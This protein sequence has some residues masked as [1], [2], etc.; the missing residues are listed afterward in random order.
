MR[1]CRIGAHCLVIKQHR[2]IRV[3]PS[4]WCLQWDKGQEWAG[5]VILSGFQGCLVL[6][7]LT[8]CLLSPALPLGCEDQHC[9]PVWGCSCV[10][11][12][13]CCGCRA[14]PVY[15]L[16]SLILQQLLVAH[17]TNKLRN[18]TAFEP[19]ASAPGWFWLGSAALW[20]LWFLYR[21]GL[22]PPG[23]TWSALKACL[24]E[25]LLLVNR[26]SSCWVCRARS[27]TLP[28]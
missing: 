16:P 28:V 1:L 27:S 4:L 26:G 6:G 22:G 14:A 13:K 19:A 24:V 10:N 21:E 11:F 5:S 3:A 23:C 9:S 18:W 12:Q 25:H 17:V 20:D 2:E 15:S 8:W 7:S